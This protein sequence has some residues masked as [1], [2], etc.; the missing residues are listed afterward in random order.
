MNRLFYISILIAFSKFLLAQKVQLF[1]P[2]NIPPSFSG[3]FGEPRTDH[4]HSGVD[5]RTQGIIGLK[6][7]AAEQGY[8]S[9]VKVGA[10]GFGKAIYIDHPNGKT[11]VYAHLD[12]F[13]GK[14]AK[15]VEDAQYKNQSFEIELFPKPHEFP[16]NKGDIIGI[17]GN[18]GSSGGPHLHFEIRETSTQKIIDPFNYFSQ[19]AKI[20]EIAPVFT[21]LFIYEFDSINY[22]V[23]SIQY[24]VYN[25][26]FNGKYFSIPSTVQVSGSIGI[27]TGIYDAINSTSLNTGVKKVEVKVN[28]SPVFFLN[29][30]K[31]AFD[32]TRYANGLIDKRVGNGKIIRLWI[33]PNNSFSGIENVKKHGLINIKSDSTYNIEIT[34]YDHSNNSSNLIFQVSGKQSIDCSDARTVQGIF[35]KWN[36]EN[37][38]ETENYRVVFPKNALFHNVLFRINEYT[39]PSFPYPLIIVHTPRTQLFKKYVLEFKLETI[40]DS[41]RNKLYIA[42][43]NGKGQEYVGCSILNNKLSGI[44]SKFGSYTV[45]IDTAPPEIVPQ[46][47]IPNSK[48]SDQ[49]DIRFQLR[50]NTGIKTYAGYIDEKWTLFEW[51]PKTGV[52]SHEFHG[53]RI[54][55]KQWHKLRIVATD[56]LNNTSEFYTT[57][58]W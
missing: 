25:P 4:F 56:Y 49:K 28:G 29:L 13:V 7:Y 14:I 58:Y 40:P 30:N 46:N 6:V 35:A 19:W 38:F 39:N 8:I 44:C 54:Q 48:I 36:E 15:Y 11:T 50:D 43:L 47:I 37:T 3:S 12:R 17:S 16:V 10:T 31:F 1:P 52:L 2:L 41:Q 27:A 51:D 21:N 33:D 20:D 32:E 23:D 26:K 42:R 24:N 18:S 57:F 55:L 22:L 53:N 45:L 9:R 34:A 5:L